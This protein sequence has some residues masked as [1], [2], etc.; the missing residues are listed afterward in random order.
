MAQ[1]RPDL[2]RDHGAM[3]ASR[4]IADDAG[5]LWSQAWAFASIGDAENLRGVLDEMGHVEFAEF[6][7]YL[8]PDFDAMPS[9]CLL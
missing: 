6:C 5:T 2:F 3:N 4:V 1:Q 7:A 8:N 9:S